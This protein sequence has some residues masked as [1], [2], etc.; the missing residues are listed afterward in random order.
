[1]DTKRVVAMV[2]KMVMVSNDDDNNNHDNNDNRDNNNDE[3]N[4]GDKD[5][6][7]DDNTDDEDEGN[8]DN[9]NKDNSND[10]EDKDGVAVVADGFVGAGGVGGGNRGGVGGS[11]IGGRWVVAVVGLAVA[12]GVEVLAVAWRGRCW[13]RRMANHHRDTAAMLRSIFVWCEGVC[14]I[15]FPFF[16]CSPFAKPIA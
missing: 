6:K 15:L 7:E 4:H 5:D 13:R 12:D 9:N 10:N 14:K 8:D 2:T 16:S 11:S 3:D 1:M